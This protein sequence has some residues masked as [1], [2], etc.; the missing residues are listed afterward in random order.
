MGAG[1]C[2]TDESGESTV[3]VSDIKQMCRERHLWDVVVTLRRVKQNAIA[4]MGDAMLKVLGARGHENSP[5]FRGE[6]RPTW[7]RTFVS[8]WS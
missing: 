3:F 4:S 5:R 8:Q 7:T 2:A 6:Y 1:G